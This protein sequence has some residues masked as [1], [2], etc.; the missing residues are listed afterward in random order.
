M[1][2]VD[3]ADTVSILASFGIFSSSNQGPLQ[4]EVGVGWG[5]ESVTLALWSWQPLG[6]IEI[7]ATLPK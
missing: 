6:V 4:Q 2:L 7:A 3:S 5:L 1:D